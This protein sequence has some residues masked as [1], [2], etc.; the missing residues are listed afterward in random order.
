MTKPTLED[1]QRVLDPSTPLGVMNL[2]LLLYTQELHNR[3]MT[4]EQASALM[5]VVFD[6]VVSV[7]IQKKYITVVENPTV[8]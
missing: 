6:K 3:G 4:Q 1:Q 5:E 7:L 8:H 2:T